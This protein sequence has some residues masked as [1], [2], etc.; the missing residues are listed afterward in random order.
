MSSS[1][2]Q[3]KELRFFKAYALGQLLVR[4]LPRDIEHGHRIATHWRDYLLDLPL[5]MDLWQNLKER[6]QGSSLEDFLRYQ[7]PFSL[8]GRQ[9]KK[10]L[11]QKW[12]KAKRL[13]SPLMTALRE[14][15]RPPTQYRKHNRPE[16]NQAARREDIRAAFETAL[17]KADFRTCEGLLQDS[18]V[19]TAPREKIAYRVLAQLTDIQETTLQRWLHLRQ[20]SIFDEFSKELRAPA[21]LILHHLGIIESEEIQFWCNLL[22]PSQP[23]PQK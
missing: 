17:S 13:Y 15:V 20:Q 5:D 8:P 16:R 21:V 10:G 18:G 3:E 14:K 19:I 12:Q 11:A 9:E 4:R 2:D 23:A 6:R 22:Y 7:R 1:W